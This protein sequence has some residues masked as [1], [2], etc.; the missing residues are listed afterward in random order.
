MSIN[1]RLNEKVRFEELFD[2]RL[3]KYGVFEHHKETATPTSRCLTDGNNCLWVYGAEVVEVLSMFG[4]RN[5]SKT[6]LEAIEEV[7]GTEIFSE[8]RPQFWGFDTE[9]EWFLAQNEV[10]ERMEAELYIEIMKYVRGGP[11][12]FAPGASGEVMAIIASDL[13]VEY[14]YLGSPD[15]KAEL[16]QRLQNNYMENNV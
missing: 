6:M 1:Y 13:I 9:E 4:P 5:T 14:P 2:G 10:T 3:K 16:M 15:G 7:F 12:H 8:H 11:H